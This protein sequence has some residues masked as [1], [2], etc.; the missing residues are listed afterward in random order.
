MT[1]ATRKASMGQKRVAPAAVLLGMA[2]VV[3]GL[4]V[5]TDWNPGYPVFRPLLIFITAMGPVYLAAGVT[6]WRSVPMG[7]RAAGAIVVL[8]AVVLGAVLVLHSAELGVAVGSVRTM[9]FRTVVWLLLLLFLGVAWLGRRSLGADR[10][11]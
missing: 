3:T 9:V 2:T 11:T 7:K 6:A 8:K 1:Q 4:R 5:L 10:V